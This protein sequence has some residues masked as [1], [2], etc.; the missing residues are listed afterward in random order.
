MPRLPRQ[1]SDSGIYHIMLR[2]INQQVIFEDDEDYFKFVETLENYKAVS[3]YKVFAYCLMSNHIHILIK[4]EKED[5]D[6]IMKRIA[7]S[8]VYWYNWKY[9]RKGHLFQD[10]FK[11]EPIEDDSYFLTVLRYI[12]QNPVKAG[13]VKSIDDYRFSSYND[14]IEENSDIVDSDFAFSL[15]KK[16]EFIA[17]ND[18]KNDDVCLDI[19]PKEFRIN[20]NDARKMIKKVSKCD[21]ATEFQLLEQKQR[22]IY[23]K[24][25]KYKGLSIRQISR[26]T[27][28]S[29]AVVRKI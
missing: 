14:Y 15:L 23:I 22:D 1:K 4:V 10:R 16:D 28:V 26:L 9:Y 7:G 19:Y 6:L 8:Y 17:F 12:H 21:N 2:G 3:G 11:S 18:E 5:L 25:L 27:G 24:R 13:I 29:F 20:D